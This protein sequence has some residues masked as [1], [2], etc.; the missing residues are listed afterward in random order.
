MKKLRIHY[1]QHVHFEDLGCIED[2][3]HEKGHILTGTQ[4]Y[5]NSN[6]PE[7]SDFDWLII[8]GGPMSIHDEK[9]YSWLAIEKQ[10]IK[11]AIHFNKKV[12]GICLGSQLIASVLGST[13]YPNQHKEIGW[14]PITTTPIVSKLMPALRE[15]RNYTVFHWHGETF[16]LPPKSP[17]LASSEACKNQAFLY[18]NQVLGL[19]FHLEVT[20]KLLLKMTNFGQDELVS[21]RYIQPLGN[22]LSQKQY[23]I[24][25]NTIMFEILNHFETL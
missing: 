10:F 19:Q 15:Q 9:Q 23:L 18:N 24:Q 11:Q 8:M 17:L 2:W 1:L 13:I 12:I 16:N 3:A 20:E 5:G 21:N 4:F 25:N 14:F 7:I 6:L 22:I